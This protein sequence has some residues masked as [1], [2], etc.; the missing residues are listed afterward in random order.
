MT[1]EILI[2][3][4]VIAM[5]ITIGACD[6][7][8]PISPGPALPE[9]EVPQPE[10]EMQPFER[11]WTRELHNRDD[12]GNGITPIPLGNGRE[13]AFFHDGDEHTRLF[14][15]DSSSGAVIDSFLIEYPGLRARGLAVFP[16]SGARAMG[17]M[18]GR[19]F[20]FSLMNG[21]V[22]WI[23]DR[24]GIYGYKPPIDGYV[25][26]STGLFEP[27]GLANIV[28][29]DTSNGHVELVY[30]QE[31]SLDPKAR[32]RYSHPTYFRLPGGDL[33]AV[34]VESGNTFNIDSM[35]A[36]RGG[37]SYLRAFNLD[38]DSLL[39][40]RDS[41]TPAW[42]T[43]GFGISRGPAVLYEGMLLKTG[44]DTVYALRPETGETIWSYWIGRHG[45]S[46]DRNRFTR[47][48]AGTPLVVDSLHGRVY[49]ACDNLDVYCL[50]ART[51]QRIW[52]SPG[53]TC[54][55]LVSLIG[56]GMLIV[57]STSG[58]AHVYNKHNGREIARL[59]KP[60]TNGNIWNAPYYDPTTKRLYGYDGARAFCDRINFEVPGD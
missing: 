32:N 4:A 46:D 30:T 34:A 36:G 26:S 9:V 28:R 49:F 23:T 25:Y 1:K 59:K 7:Q 12:F 6:P 5:A 41:M 29:Y 47:H 17:A 48:V 19:H 2:A 22:D 45:D 35:A 8:A 40:A 18:N 43:G 42:L 56:D 60:S 14:H 58:D 16:I 11:L 53:H 52:R 44:W 24:E 10:P 38:A 50:D 13:F 54:N 20:P 21:E 39:W 15:L 57:G 51:G 37:W 55:G 31:P 27:G 33:A 3:C